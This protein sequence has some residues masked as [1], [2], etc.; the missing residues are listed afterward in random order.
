MSTEL[1]AIF[2]DLGGTLFSYRDVPRRSMPLILAAGERLGVTAEPRELGRAYRAASRDAFSEYAPRP[3]YLH[4]DLFRETYRGFA[5]RLGAEAT[6]DFLDWFHE[7]QRQVMIDG[8]E[9]RDDCLDTLAELRKRGLGTSIVSN[10]DDD[11]LIPMVEQSGLHEVLDHWMS[12]EEAKS[13]KPDPGFFEHALEKQGCRAGEVLFVG[14]SR[15]HDI[16]GARG[17]GMTSVLIVEPGVSA[18]TG[19]SL[20]TADPHHEINQLAELI[21]LVKRR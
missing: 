3:Y 1:R 20:P 8:M 21:E 13:C 11:Y 12:S 9:L 15:E 19:E 7:A 5:E 6:E 10:I 2:F 14:D 18:P 17:V 4:R 16:V